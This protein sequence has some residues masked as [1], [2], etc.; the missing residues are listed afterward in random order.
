MRKSVALHNPIPDH[1]HNVP[2]RFHVVYT[3]NYFKIFRDTRIPMTYIFTHTHIY[4][5]IYIY[6]YTL[7][8]THSHTHAHT[9][10]YIYISTQAPT[11][12]HTHTYIH[13]QC[14][15]YPHTRRTLCVTQSHT[16]KYTHTQLYTCIMLCAYILYK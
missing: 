1:L 11:H 12:T 8:H 15:S 3:L 9:N 4:I 6:I 13:S 5:Y 16:Q 14:E 10:V 7:A 2:T